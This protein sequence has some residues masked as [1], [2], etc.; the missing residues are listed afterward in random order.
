MFYTKQM[1][2]GIAK[3]YNFELSPVWW[4]IMLGIKLM[5]YETGIW[6][7]CMHLHCLKCHS[8]MRPGLD[9][10]HVCLLIYPSKKVNVVCFYYSKYMYNFLLVLGYSYLVN[11]GS[12][13]ISAQMVCYSYLINAGSTV[14][15]A[16]TEA[17]YSYL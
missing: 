14:I 10:L 16:N 17:C 2:N 3:Q 15:S 12:T 9:L 13:V 11:A 6:H 4:G 1:T 5:W 8:G 7:T